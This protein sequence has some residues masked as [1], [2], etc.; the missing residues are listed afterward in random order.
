MSEADSK[1]YCSVVP[2]FPKK[3]FFFC[4]FL[5]GDNASTFLPAFPIIDNR[6]D[7]ATTIM[8]FV[9]YLRDEKDIEV[10][11]E[12]IIIPIE[13][14]KSFALKREFWEGNHEQFALESRFYEFLGLLDHPELH[15]LLVLP[16]LLEEGNN[17]MLEAALPLKYNVSRKEITNFMQHSDYVVDE[18]ASSAA[19]YTIGKLFRY[20]WET[21]SFSEIKEKRIFQEARRN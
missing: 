14:N 3:A 15:K 7:I 10:M 2:Y 8:E 1:K 13:Y 20:N 9:D 17:F 18:R 11:S 19:I 21:K 6:D 4:L 5:K 12:S 16:S